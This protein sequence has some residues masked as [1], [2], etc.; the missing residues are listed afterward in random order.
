MEFPSGLEAVTDSGFGQKVFGLGR[1]I[2]EL[3]AQVADIDAQVMA[4]LDVGRAP[5]FAQQVALGQY[6]A[7]VAEQG[8][9]QAVFDGRQMNFLA[10][11]QN[12][13]PREVDRNSAALAWGAALRRGAAFPDCRVCQAIALLCNQNWIKKAFGVLILLTGIIIPGGADKWL[14]A[15]IIAILPDAWVWATTLF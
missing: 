7:G 3:L 15:R 6:L 2:L 4:A 9:Q 5:D 14:E 12:D 11:P 10:R 13:A 1:V 8:G